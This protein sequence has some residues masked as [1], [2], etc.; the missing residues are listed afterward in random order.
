MALRD[1]LERGEPID[2]AKSAAL[3]EFGNVSL[4][5]EVTRN[6]TGSTAVESIGKDLRYAFRVLARSRGFS[7]VSILALALG[8]GCNSAIYSVVHSV[9]L[10][11]LPFPD[12]HR[13]VRLWDSYGSAGNY[14]PVSYPDFRDWRAW[15]HSFS[16]MAAYSGA[17]FTLTGAGDPIHIDGVVCSASLFN[18]LKV[19]PP[20]GRTFG[21]DEDR[22]AANNGVDS[23]ILSN[24]LWKK[25]SA[26]VQ[27]FWAAFFFWT[28]NRLPSSG[29]CLPDST[30]T[31]IRITPIS[32][33]RPPSLRNLRRARPNL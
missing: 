23:I 2:E 12:S 16:G 4:V 25:R 9:L 6:V 29:S 18:V 1:R 26:K 19:Q 14:A 22:P 11:P 30:R 31:R 28:E 33:S 32:G 21:P 5:K 20:L 3:R 10:S 24:R 8:I 7:L 15:N 17:S 27:V 13:L